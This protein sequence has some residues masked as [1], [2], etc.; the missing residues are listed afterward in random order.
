M[1]PLTNKELN[2]LNDMLSAEDL[3][4]KTC[5]AALPQATQNDVHQFLHHV[6]GEHQRRYDDILHVVQQHESV[7]H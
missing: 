3:L 6:V 1:Q 4:I 5:A 7:A 2:Y